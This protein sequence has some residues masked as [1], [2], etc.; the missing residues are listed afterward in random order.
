WLGCRSIALLAV[1]FVIAGGSVSS[2][3]IV[4]LQ[5]ARTFVPTSVTTTSTA[6]EPTG[7]VEPEGGVMVTTSV[8]AVPVTLGSGK[9]TTAEQTPGSLETVKSA[10]Q[11]S[12]TCA[13]TGAATS[14]ASRI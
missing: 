1:R 12:V 4:K 9:F 6:F 14:N 3:V 7:N 10:G 2:T 5:L 8:A 13:M 11:V